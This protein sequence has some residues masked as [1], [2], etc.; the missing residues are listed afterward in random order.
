LDN[1]SFAIVLPRLSA[2]VHTDG[3]ESD[4][5]LVAAEA[6]T[7]N[8]RN[9][10]GSGE[11]HELATLADLKLKLADRTGI[12]AIRQ[13]VTY[14]VEFRELKNTDTLASMG[15]EDG[16]TVHLTLVGGLRGGGGCQSRKRNVQQ[17]DH[18]D[19]GASGYSPNSQFDNTALES[20]HHALHALTAT[21]AAKSRSLAPLRTRRQCGE[22]QSEAKEGYFDKSD[23]VFYCKHCWHNNFA[24]HQGTAW[25]DS[26]S[27]R[28][29]MHSARSSVHS[30][31]CSGFSQMCTETPDLGYTFVSIDDHPENVRADVLESCLHGAAMESTF[32]QAAAVNAANEN[33]A[34]ECRLSQTSDID[35]VDLIVA[36]R[37]SKSM[38]TALAKSLPSATR[39]NTYGS[40][41]CASVLH[42][43]QPSQRTANHLVGSVYCQDSA[44]SSKEL[45]CGRSSVISA[46]STTSGSSMEM[47]SIHNS[48]SYPATPHNPISDCH[49]SSTNDG[50]GAISIVPPHENTS[51]NN[52]TRAMIEALQQ[53][54]INCFPSKN[55]SSSQGL[56]TTQDTQRSTMQEMPAL[57]DSLAVRPRS[58]S[59]RPVSVYSGFEVAISVEEWPSESFVVPRMSRSNSELLLKDRATR[60]GTFL[61][62]PFGPKRPDAHII[63]VIFGEDQKESRSLVHLLIDREDGQPYTC[64]DEPLESLCFTPDAV[65]HALRLQGETF[66]FPLKCPVFIAGDPNEPMESSS[67][68]IETQRSAVPKRH[69]TSSTHV[70]TFPVIV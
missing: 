1:R 16:S 47:A 8:V 67:D 23:G 3:I 45:S 20:F 21:G 34:R 24:A 22:C 62:R 43:R 46:T 40:G 9:V 14:G 13:R 41:T 64:N 44:A 29:S 65:V 55:I 27:T 38:A 19:V 50:F 18:S 37:R 17:G 60:T 15:I 5:D 56:P 59:V 69:A 70:C 54:L 58:I 33:A 42:S 48:I 31:R 4:A 7:G 12:P 39:L 6:T 68:A 61:M 49:L 53:Q 30:N 32:F 26:S 66:R 35:V 25:V 63:S 51:S 52:L 28:S 11:N 10:D 2:P 36:N 57:L